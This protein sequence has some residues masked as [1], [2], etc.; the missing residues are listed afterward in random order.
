ML[1]KYL[2]KDVTLLI[3]NGINRYNQA[4]KSKS[5]SY[6]WEE[7]LVKMANNNSFH[8]KSIPESF[9][10]TEIFK[11]IS[12][13]SEK[14]ES[15]LKEEF[16]EKLKMIESTETQK[17]IVDL[18]RQFNVDILTSNFDLT[19][20][21][22]YNYEPMSDVK[23]DKGFTDFYPWQRY[24]SDKKNSISHIKIWHIQGDAHYPRSL[25]LTVEDYIKNYQYFENYDPL[26]KKSKYNQSVTWLN[27]FFEKKLLIIGVALEEQEFFLRQLLYKK[28]EYIKE[29][30][31]GYYIVFKSDNQLFV[32]DK[33]TTKYKRLQFFAKSVG[34]KIIILDKFSDIYEPKPIDK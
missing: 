25:R 5:N 34:L 3:G 9:P 30:I 32:K 10:Y 27:T 24:Y 29:N 2:K 6:S 7:I 33:E 28:K 20:E 1:H 11:I 31:I 17:Y 4:V 14:E 13:K 15:L 19:L 18:C 26:N 16:I 22:V 21:Q 23:L 12:I 8:I